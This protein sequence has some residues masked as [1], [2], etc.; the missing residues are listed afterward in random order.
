MYVMAVIH[1]LLNEHHVLS[2]QFKDR[3][4]PYF[5]EKTDHFIHEFYNFLRSPYDMVGYDRQLQYNQ[6]VHELGSSSSTEIGESDVEVVSEIPAPINQRILTT[7][8]EVINVSDT[9]ST[10][11]DV[12][13]REPTPPPLVTIS[14]SDDDDDAVVFVES[15]NPGAYKKEEVS[16]S[17]SDSVVFVNKTESRKRRSM[18]RRIP[19]KK[20][21]VQLPDSDSPAYKRARRNSSS[22]S[23]EARSKK[24]IVRRKK[25]LV[26]RKC[27]S[28]SSSSDSNDAPSSYRS[29]EPSTSNSYNRTEVKC[30][31]LDSD[32]LPLSV[33][34]GCSKYL[35]V[36][37]TRPTDS[38]DSSDSLD[39]E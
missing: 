17:E 39:S 37:K 3:I 29:G 30:E 26:K 31:S 21:F 10:N 38:T 6:R 16:E 14:D 4:Q 35:S 33:L 18:A 19:L 23:S 2:T 32:D 15:S 13:I 12:V 7:P 9:D 20:R 28:S 5:N 27:T 34:P 22:S 36:N 24:T 1:D 8:G 25:R 11:S